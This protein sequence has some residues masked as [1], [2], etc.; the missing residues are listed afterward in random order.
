MKLSILS[1]SSMQGYQDCSMSYYFGKDARLQPKKSHG[2]DVGT[3]FHQGMEVYIKQEY[4]YGFAQCVKQ[5]NKTPGF[6]HFPD[7][8]VK[9]ASEIGEAWLNEHKLPDI[10]HLGEGK[11]G[12]KFPQAELAFGPAGDEMYGNVVEPANA[13][14]FASGLKV[15]GL[16]DMIHPV[17]SHDGSGLMIVTDWKTNKFPPKTI[18]DK[19]QPQLYALV[20]HKLTGYPVRCEFWYVREPYSGPRVYHPSL[21]ELA[22]LEERLLAVQQRIE[23]DT[24]PKANPSLDCNWCY[25]NYACADF[26]DWVGAAPPVNGQAQTWESM[27]LN[28]LADVF[29]FWRDRFL[30]SKKM[31]GEIQRVVLKRMRQQGLKELNDWT[32]G[33]MYDTDWSL[34]AQDVIDEWGGIEAMPTALKTELTRHHK[35]RSIGSPF[36]RQKR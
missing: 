16:I 6:K 4:R 1:A 29:G 30:A 24:S 15:H 32:I 20:V 19:I 26:T 27:N 3:C 31:K 14:T 5:A 34:H 18:A 10:F 8:V 25:H 13:V 36:L 23:A 12:L 21:E 33:H 35:Q 7:S 11:N 28:D 2:G 22:G 9:E 17:F